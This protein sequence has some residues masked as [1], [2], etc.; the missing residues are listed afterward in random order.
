MRYPF[1]VPDSNFNDASLLLVAHG[2]TV[3]PDSA[4]AAQLHAE[5]LRAA[6][7]FH[8]VSVAYWKEPPFIR[9]VATSLASP[10]VFV[11]PLFL[12]A[13]YFTEQLVPRELGLVERPGDAFARVQRRG[14]ATW[15]YCEPI[16]THPRIPEVILAR[17]GEVWSRSGQAGFHEPEVTLF[18]A[19]HGTE[20]DKR[21]RES[22]EAHARAI[23][24]QRAFADVQAVFLEESP[25]ISD[26]ARLSRTRDLIVVPFFVSEGMHSREDVPVLLGEGP[27]RVRQ[28]LERG[29]PTW[30]N[31]LERDGKRIWYTEPVGTAP[32]MC[33]VILDR[34]REA[35]R[36]P[37]AANAR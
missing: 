9:D 27:E 37:H 29:E 33:E 22:A 34:V 15:F 1:P 16:G 8:S 18:I 5:R 4:L 24:Q 14:E 30:I 31:P 13:G 12:S 20:K 2:S 36:A 32:R 10:R 25:L 6:N 23:R 35:A 28:R 7:C 21:S 19:A 17:V 3:N 11:V 26:C